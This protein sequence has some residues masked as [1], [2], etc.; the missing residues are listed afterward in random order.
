MVG[1]L[2]AGVVC[3][4]IPEDTP[5]QREKMVVS[6]KPLSNPKHSSVRLLCQ[7]GKTD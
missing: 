7:L 1:K 2:F 5:N 3:M 6:S 4:F